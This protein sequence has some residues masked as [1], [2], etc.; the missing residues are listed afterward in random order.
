M[1]AIIATEMPGYREALRQIALNVG[2]Q[3]ASKDCVDYENVVSRLAVG[4]ADLLLVMVTDDL[5]AAV[6]LIQ[7]ISPQVPVYAIGSGQ[8]ASQV[9]RLLR[10]GAKE[11]LEQSSLREELIAA[12]DRVGQ[13]SGIQKQRRGKT[14]AVTAPNPGSGVTTV[15]SGLAF[16]LAAKHPGQVLLAELGNDVPELAIDLDFHP[17]NS[18]A[19]VLTD[20]ERMDASIVKQSA[21]E[22]PAGV[23]LLA[24]HPE[25]LQ[26][27]PA[28]A[29]AIKHA[30][31]LWRTLYDFTVIDLGFSVHPT[32]QEVL[33]FADQIVVVVRL[34]VPS[35]RW[36]RQYLKQLHE[37]GIPID[38]IKTVIN[39]YGQSRQIT[40]RK[41][42]ES[43]GLAPLVWIPEDSG[44][45]NEAINHGQP[46]V[47]IARRAKIT[48]QFA[49]LAQHL[50]GVAPKKK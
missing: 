49:E 28:S 45:I 50:N 21:H 23:H 33:R 9:L 2:L 12:L 46:L 16:A 13:D 40:W 31:R 25:T 47:Q 32:A 36:T 44:T 35:L 41:V 37:L 34:D 3:C 42:E 8:E 22:H 1:R 38:K 6:A 4:P 24:H 29:D 27:E 48:R 26:V 43:I 11:Y 5:D 19:D 10:A 18:I 15:A 17:R 14:L 20:W 7:G 30:L 39:R